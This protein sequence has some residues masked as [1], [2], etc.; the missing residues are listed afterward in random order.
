MSILK[1]FKL[2][3][4]LKTIDDQLSSPDGPLNK[5][6]RILRITIVSAN[7]S[8]HSAIVSGSSRGL[9]LHLTPAQKF[10]IGKRA[11]EYGVMNAQC[12]YKTTFPDLPL[13]E[14]SVRRFK[15]LIKKI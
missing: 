5:E 13:K 15:M 10:Q 7:A 2:K 4:K 9:Y 14:T 8:V 3:E 6:V 11:S 12:Y 1:Y